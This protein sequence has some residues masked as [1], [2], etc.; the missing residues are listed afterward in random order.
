MASDTTTVFAG[1]LKTLRAA[2]PGKDLNTILKVDKPIV[3]A[4]VDAVSVET[5]LNTTYARYLGSSV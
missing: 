3:Q 4:S 5:D 1:Y 2:N